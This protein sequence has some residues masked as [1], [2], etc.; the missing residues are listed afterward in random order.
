MGQDATTSRIINRKRGREGIE[1][2][3]ISKNCKDCQYIIK[4]H[5][6]KYAEPTITGHNHYL[7]DV[8]QWDNIQP[9]TGESEKEQ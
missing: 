4:K 1:M 3:P 9:K 2:K 7:V 8:M 6:K 5:G